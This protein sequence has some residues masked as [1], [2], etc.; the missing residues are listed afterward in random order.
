MLDAFTFLFEPDLTGGELEVPTFL[1]TERRDVIFW[2]EAERSF[3]QYIQSY[4][5]P[6]V[7]IECKNTADVAPDHI[8]QT[9]AYL[10]ARLG[11]FGLVVSRTRASEALSCLMG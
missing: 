8:T 3:W 2:N 5:S 9:A 6:L 10:G 4:G 7:L 1:G 11:M